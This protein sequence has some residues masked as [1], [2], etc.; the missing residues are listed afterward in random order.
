MQRGERLRKGWSRGEPVWASA[1]SETCVG[2]KEKTRMKKKQRKRGGG[3]Y[4]QRDATVV[5]VAK[6]CG[7]HWSSRLRA[8]ER[9]K[10]T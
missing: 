2:R 7:I 4:R 3:G 5:V 6:C 9:R 1:S 10:S 8:G